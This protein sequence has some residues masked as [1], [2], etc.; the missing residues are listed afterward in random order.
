MT[1]TE[2]TLEWESKFF[3]HL[4]KMYPDLVPAF[5]SVKFFYSPGTKNKSDIHS[6]FVPFKD[7]QNN[8]ELK[9]KMNDVF[10]EFSRQVPV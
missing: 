10:N 7:T 3:K 4:D 9:D 8:K 6:A 2:R 1:D 5:L